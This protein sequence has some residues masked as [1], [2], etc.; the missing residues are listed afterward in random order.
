MKYLQLL[1]KAASKGEGSRGG[2][3]IGHTR[4]G[5]PIYASNGRSAWKKH[6]KGFNEQDHKDAEHVNSQYQTHHEKVG[7]G[8][9]DAGDT[10][11]E[12]EHM[13]V[14][15][16]HAILRDAHKVTRNHGDLG[17]E[18]KKHEASLTYE[19]ISGDAKMSQ[20]HAGEHDSKVHRR[21]QMQRYSRNLRAQG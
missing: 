7:G 3:I 2:R 6:H 1:I 13:R 8:K 12:D 20:K 14:G 21:P 11:A 15:I 16:H 9:G 10:N 4:S 19:D 18:G 5:K 17:G